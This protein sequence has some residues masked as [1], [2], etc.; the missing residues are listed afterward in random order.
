M[1]APQVFHI[2]TEFK[3]EIG[4]ALTSSRALQQAVSGVSVAAD[5]ALMSFQRMGIGVVAQMGLGTGGVLGV[6][7]EAIQASEKFDSTQRK[8]ANTFLSN[9]DK[10]KG[11]P[12]TFL[13]AMQASSA[14]MDEIQAKARQFG[15]PAS[16]LSNTVAQIAPAL[17]NEGVAG[18]NLSTAVDMSRGL[19]KSAPVLGVD[20]N[21][22]QGQLLDLVT[23]RAS[24]G[25]TLAMRLMNET[26]AFKDLKTGGVN[27]AL[28]TNLNQ[29]TPFKSMPTAQNVNVS[30]DVGRLEQPPVRDTNGPLSAFNSLAEKTPQQVSV[31]I[32]ARALNQSS[33]LEMKGPLSALNSVSTPRNS[34]LESGAREF[35][36]SG[37]THG[38]K[39]PLASFNAL[40]AAQRVE[41]LNKALL[42]F[43]SNADILKANANSLTQQLQV[44]SDTMKGMF[45]ILRPIGS[46]LADFL[47]PAVARFNVMVQT[48][49]ASISKQ[50]G[51]MLRR[52]LGQ[53]EELFENLFQMRSLK[54]D[55]EATSKVFSVAG[56]TGVIGAGLKFLGVTSKLAAPWVSVLAGA[57]TVFMDVFARTPTIVSKIALIGI[58]VGALLALLVAFPPLAGIIAVS[59]VLTALFQMLSRAQ[60]IAAVEDVK[61]LPE[62]MDDLSRVVNAFSATMGRL[63]DPFSQIFDGLA[64]WISPVFQV[65]SWVDFLTNALFKLTYAFSFVE[66]AFSGLLDAV[67]TFMNYFTSSQMLTDPTGI[68][69]QMANSFSREFDRVM[70]ENL[71]SLSDPE[72]G[73]VMN[74]ITNISKVEI[75]NEFKEQLEP[76]RIAFTLVEQ[77]KKTAQNPSQGSGRSFSGALVGR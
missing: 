54:S 69:D 35:H 56:I 46:V 45:S 72:T 3:F 37:G 25:D 18:T 65:S 13:E 19:L 59:T 76:D 17:F 40:P 67:S 29:P 34:N 1:I 48:H 5:N 6:L 61:A 43:G 36:A 68:F 28:G 31:N 23:G 60:G 7:Y 58:G 52:V 41:V 15:L 21:M 10:I 38:S 53:P 26:Q 2:L 20:P 42:Q 9:Q 49:G 11:G 77:L 33:A 22:V 74:Q 8:L 24:A 55:L 66:A 75:R 30:V 62:Q 27:Q 14:V 32:D 64:H 50:L 12:V 4:S 70:N 39:S 16:A 73:A 63:F 51:I 47:A 71:S 57:V 44:L